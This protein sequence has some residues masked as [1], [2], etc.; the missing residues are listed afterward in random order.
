MNDFGGMSGRVFAYSA[1]F[2]LTVVVTL[3][4]LM[5]WH[6]FER[7]IADE[8]PIVVQLVTLAP[9]T[10]ATQVA[11]TPPK[12]EK[13]PEVANL[14]IPKP[15]ELKPEP[16]KPQP[17]PESKPEPP[18][19]EAAKPVPPSPPP[20]EPKPQ[21]AKAEP[22][23]ELPKPPPVKPE[24]PKKKEDVMSD[25]LLRNLAKRSPVRTPEEAPRQVAA[26]PS[27]GSSQPIAPLGPKL[28]AS[29]MD[30]VVQQISDCWAVP[31]GARDIAT[32]FANIRIDMNADATVRNAQ[33]IDHNNLP[34]AESARRAALN[35]RCHQ[36]K[37]PLDKYGGAN[38]W[39]VIDLTFT[40]GGIR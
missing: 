16:P 27:K 38:G 20:P 3:Y 34:F 6:L 9:E 15:P 28:T 17:P 29:E 36:L 19:P 10:R 30:L 37:L 12:P 2:H 18:K 22:K 5:H 4:V 7:K 31:A 13:P 14:E 32:L 39:S 11:R 25:D 24:P 40:P 26:A 8:T 33:I 35:P 21:E 23:P 1:G